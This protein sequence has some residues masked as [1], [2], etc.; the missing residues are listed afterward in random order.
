MTT[1]RSIFLAAE[2]EEAAVA[3]AIERL[4]GSFE[5][6]LFVEAQG[7]GTYEVVLRARVA[8]L[9]KPRMTSEPNLLNAALWMHPDKYSRK[10]RVVK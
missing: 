6:P 9:P 1:G 2:S 3:T 4:P 7:D 8:D 10:L 5:T